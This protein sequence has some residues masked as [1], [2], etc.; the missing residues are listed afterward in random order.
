FVGA[1]L[2][3][4]ALE[5]HL[6]GEALLPLQAS[7]EDLGHA[8]E[9]ET[10]YQLVLAE[11]FA[12]LAH[13]SQCILRVFPLRPNRVPDM[14]CHLPVFCQVRGEALASHTCARCRTYGT[15]EEHH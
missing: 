10:T 13:A 5:H 11:G 12:A 15:T 2:R 6:L 9:R 3:E 14:R 1:E 4:N 7:E 8:A